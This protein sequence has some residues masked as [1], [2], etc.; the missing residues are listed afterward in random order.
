MYAEM[1]GQA[2]INPD[3]FALC[4]EMGQPEPGRSTRDLMAFSA[5]LDRY[6]AL[7]KPIAIA[8]LSAPSKPPNPDDLGLGGEH[9]PGYWR[10]PWSPEA[11]AA[12]MTNM[13][14]VA[15]SK[16]YVHSIAW[17]EMYDEP[18]APPSAKP[19]AVSG[20]RHDGLFDANLQPKLALWRLAEIRQAIRA[21]QSPANLPETPA[22]G[23]M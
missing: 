3:L 23:T 13:F 1:L 5:L 20:A 8:A 18:A 16:P 6:A 22:V 15:A 14:A 17:H 4:I 7:E 19:A 12:W 9:D 21:K 2:G 11:Q 10:R